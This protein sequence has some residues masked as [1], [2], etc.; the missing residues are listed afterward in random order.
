VVLAVSDTGHGMDPI[1][2]AQIFEPFFTTKEQGQGTGLGLPTVYGIVK[3]SGGSIYVYSEPGQGTT[4]KVYLPCLGTC[5]APE[6]RAPTVGSVARGGEVVLLA[7]DRDDVRRL[8]ARVLRKCGYRVLEA[9][10]GEAAL[11]LAGDH[12]GQ[13]HAL[14][15]D[16]VMPGMSGKVLAER[17]GASRPHTRIIFMSGYADETVLERSMVESGITFIQKPFTPSGLAAAVRGALDRGTAVRRSGG[18]LE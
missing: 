13:I 3:Q 14:L 5:A 15:T 8:T 11:A 9:E 16:A 4:F 1:T 6:V 2:K 12:S 10:S 17:L 18:S 7:E